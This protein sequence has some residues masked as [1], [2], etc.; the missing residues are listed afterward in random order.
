MQAVK[1]RNTS[2][3]RSVASALVC[4]GLKNRRNVA[5]LPGNPDFVFTMAKAAV[6]IDGDF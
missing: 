2:H 1:G 3:E 6:V 4:F 5:S